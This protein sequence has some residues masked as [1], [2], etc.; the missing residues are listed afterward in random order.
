MEE[1]GEKLTCEC[2]SVVLKKN[3]ASHIKTKKHQA[4]TG[5]PSLH[6][7]VG[8]SFADAQHTD[9]ADVE[10]DEG[11]ESDMD[12]GEDI[13]ELFSMIEELG[14]AIVVLDK[15]LDNVFDRVEETRLKTNLIL[16]EVREIDARLPF[17]PF[18]VIVK[19]TGS[20]P[21]QQQ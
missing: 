10:D 4:V 13:E 18:G 12:D 19:P 17:T 15:K 2:G 16:G 9:R 20:G 1:K 8:V 5:T 11:S 3:L 21:E 7:S 6:R 14:K